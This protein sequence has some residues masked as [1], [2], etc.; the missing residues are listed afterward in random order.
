MNQ[1]VVLLLFITLMSVSFCFSQNNA[2]S[3]ELPTDIENKIEHRHS[4]GASFFMLGNFLSDSPDYYLLTYGY[5]L[6]KKNRIFAEFNTW[7]YGEPLGT[8]AKSET[9]YPGYVRALG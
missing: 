1:K 8:Y 4:I 2:S 9:F 7:K 5:R 3:D 6:N